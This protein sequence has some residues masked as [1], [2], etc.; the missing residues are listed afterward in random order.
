MVSYTACLHTPTTQKEKEA[1]E[2]IHTYF[3]TI[4]EIPSA[5]VQSNEQA[6][7]QIA[8]QIGKVV[9]VEKV[10]RKSKVIL[11]PR[12]Q[13]E[14]QE[15]YSKM[16]EWADVV[17]FDELMKKEIKS[18]VLFSDLINSCLTLGRPADT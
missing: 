2:K 3:Q 6:Y 9:S 17:D 10:E 8:A 4:E 13:N 11:M 5:L 7:G 18:D 15:Y 12:Y 14:G 16:G 1:F